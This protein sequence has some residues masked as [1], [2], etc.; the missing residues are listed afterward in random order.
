MS[1]FIVQNNAAY[2]IKQISNRLDGFPENHPVKKT[3]HKMIYLIQKAGVNLGYNYHLYFY[4]PYSSDLDE[5]IGVLV[6]DGNIEMK[7]TAHGHRLGPRTYEIELEEFVENEVDRERID[8]IINHYI[9]G[10]RPKQLELL[11]T[12]V[13]VHEH[14]TK[15]DHESII[16][17][18]KHIKGSKYSH[19]EILNVLCEFNFLGITL[20]EQIRL[21]NIRQ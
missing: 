18:I 9:P 12:A 16:S 21:C 1:E 6:A 2:V 10:W 5:E 11:A 20:D 13:Y 3:V 15:K 4:G 7:Y 14:N 19:E 8:M 17:G